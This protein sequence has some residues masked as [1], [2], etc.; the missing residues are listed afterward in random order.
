MHQYFY[1]ATR[2]LFGLNNKFGGGRYVIV[3]DKVVFLHLS[4]CSQGGLPM[5]GLHPGGWAD[6]PRTG[7]VDGMHPTGMLSC[8][9]YV[10]F[11]LWGGGG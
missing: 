5:G 8:F 7:K 10:C 4:D 6:P 11:F 2:H 3:W 9:W 1:V